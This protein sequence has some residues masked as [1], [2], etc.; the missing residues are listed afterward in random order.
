[1]LARFGAAPSPFPC[2]GSQDENARV[3][4][5]GQNDHVRSVALNF[6][7]LPWQWQ[8]NRIKRREIA[9]E[10]ND[11]LRFSIFEKNFM[12]SI[13]DT[14]FCAFW[15]RISPACVGNANLPI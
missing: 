13:V 12:R 1:M 8:I 2:C 10:R 11:L 15:M 4:G 9:S 5:H 14:C 6:N 7:V 3:S